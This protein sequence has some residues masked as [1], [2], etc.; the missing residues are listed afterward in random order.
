MED[1]DD[2]E[3]EGDAGTVLTSAEARAQR[4][5][6][7]RPPDDAAEPVPRAPCIWK[8]RR[9]QRVENAQEFIRQQLG[10]DDESGD[11]NEGL[12]ETDEED[13]EEEEEQEEGPT[14][15]SKRPNPFID[16]EC[17]VSRRR[18]DSDSD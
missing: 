2:G 17:G 4:I 1:V 5:L 18:V 10:F 8:E 16:S 15:R 12:V 7:T 11:E 6:V 14:R 9:K 13:D 3:D